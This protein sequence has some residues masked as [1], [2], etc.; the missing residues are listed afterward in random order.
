MLAV[1]FPTLHDAS[2]SGICQTNRLVGDEVL[3]VVSALQ[4]KKA[5]I[6]SAANGGAFDLIKQEIAR[7]NVSA[8]AFNNIWLFVAPVSPSFSN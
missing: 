5:A 2:E 1:G 8:T 4:N 3:Q 7:L 6:A